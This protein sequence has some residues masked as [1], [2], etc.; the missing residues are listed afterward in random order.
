MSLNGIAVI[1]KSPL[2]VLN[3]IMHTV[4][5]WVLLLRNIHSKNTVLY[6]LL[7]HVRLCS[8][9]CTVGLELC[10]RG[11]HGIWWPCFLPVWLS[12]Q[13]CVPEKMELVLCLLRSHHPFRKSFL[14]LS[15]EDNPMPSASFLSSDLWDIFLCF[16]TISQFLRSPY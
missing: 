9:D 6:S 14:P 13:S 2:T 3:S 4:P 7:M 10:Y 8:P 15:W 1:P 12:A 16:S 11:F 5:Q